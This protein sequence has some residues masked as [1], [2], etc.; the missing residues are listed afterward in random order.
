MAT[1]S[2]FFIPC[3]FAVFTDANDQATGATYCPDWSKADVGH[4]DLYSS[5]L[6]NALA[7]VNI[8]SLLF[9]NEVASDVCHSLIDDY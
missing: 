9:S 3:D 2:N 8:P 1:V 4:C 5:S 7:L 6:D